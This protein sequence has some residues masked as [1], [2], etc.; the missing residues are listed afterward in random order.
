MTLDE[1]IRQALD[2][3]RK[4]LAVYQEAAARATGAG[5]G[6][7]SALAKEEQGHVDYLEARLR[8][9]QEQ[10]RVA[11]GDLETIL[12]P[13]EKVAEEVSRRAQA[14]QTRSPKEAQSEELELL[15]RALAAE[16][17]TSA[18]YEEMVA[19]LDA[20][21]KALF[22]PF[23]DIERGHRAL[24]QAEIDALTGTGF[25]FDVAEFRFEAG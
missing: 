12:P 9:W 24:V 2:Y 5:V 8:E 21:G 17:D 4:V 1:A 22:G 13:G 18:F 23:L 14:L 19:T 20:E 3:E 6:V 7:F 10:G 15:K 25:W 16:T 11:A